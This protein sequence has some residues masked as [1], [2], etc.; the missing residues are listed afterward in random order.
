MSVFVYVG[1]GVC[2]LYVFGLCRVLCDDGLVCVVVFITSF[3]L[4]EH[5]VS[6]ESVPEGEELDLDLLFLVLGETAHH[7]LFAAG[8]LKRRHRGSVGRGQVFNFNGLINTQ[9]NNTVN[10]MRY[11]SQESYK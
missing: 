7:R 11:Y 8:S 2:S 5:L 9:H 6:V 3:V 4:D 1:G 10:K